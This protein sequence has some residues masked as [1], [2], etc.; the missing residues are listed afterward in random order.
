MKP[1]HFS[2]TIVLITFLGL[3]IIICPSIYAQGNYGYILSGGNNYNFTQFDLTTKAYTGSISL[4][5]YS[6][7]GALNQRGTKLWVTGYSTLYI[8]NTATKL[9]VSQ[10]PL[11]SSSTTSQT[12]FSLDGSIAYMLNSSSPTSIVERDTTTYQVTASHQ[13]QNS[14]NAY[15]SLVRSK[16]G[17]KL[18]FID[19]S[20]YLYEVNTATWTSNRVSL[21]SSN[22]K[23]KLSP[24]DSLLFIWGSGNSS[25]QVYNTSSLTTAGTIQANTSMSSIDF[26]HDGTTLFV[27]FQYSSY[28]QIFNISQF[29]II[30]STFATLPNYSYD[31]ACDPNSD[32]LLYI[33]HNAFPQI[34]ILMR[35]LCR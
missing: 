24:N 31:I 3:S 1:F 18:Y 23:L 14:Y 20:Y 32:S 6:Y 5:D 33:A 4:S 29:P 10:Q 12:V 13:I 34:I 35:S 27:G 7:A 22:N 2:K 26:S 25:I 19:N 28:L 11:T 8:I 21:S 30:S 9:I 16:N 17:K 15:S